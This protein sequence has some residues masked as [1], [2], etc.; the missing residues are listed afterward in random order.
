MPK[1]KSRQIYNRGGSNRSRLEA[2]VQE[3]K[4]AR[5]TIEQKVKI[6][7]YVHDM[8]EMGLCESMN[9]AASNLGISASTLSRWKNKLPQF[10]HIARN[11]QVRSSLHM[12]RRGQL[13]DIGDTLLGFVNLLREKGIAV[14][15]KMIV[16]QACKILGPDHDFSLKS[17]A[18]R[19]ASVS[20]WMAQ[21]GLAVRTGTHQA[22]APPQTVEVM[23]V[24]FI[25]NIA[26]PAVTAFHRDKDFIMNMDQTPVFFSMHPTKSVDTIGTKTINIRIAKNASQRATVAVSITASGKQLKSLIIFKGK[27]S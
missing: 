5:F 21:N 18:A 26:R 20:R 22:Q 3:Q 24:D 2:T 6:M 9:V 13:E 15:R 17:Y 8:A 16:M 1:Q 14:S 10:L 25:V 11:D 4:R 12:G 27:F 23:A 7:E 19:G